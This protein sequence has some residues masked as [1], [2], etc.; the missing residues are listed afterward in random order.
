MALTMEQVQAMVDASSVTLHARIAT[1]EQEAVLL[2]ASNEEQRNING[3]L[4]DEAKQLRDLL[5][6]KKDEET[7][8]QK[9]TENIAIEIAK[10]RHAKEDEEKQEKETEEQRAAKEKEK[11]E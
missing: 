2:K 7:L 3:K 1:H 10:M 9:T 6:K 8:H 5:L 11:Q 4:V